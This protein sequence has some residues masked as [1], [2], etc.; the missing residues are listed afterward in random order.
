MRFHIPSTELAGDDP[1]EGFQQSVMAK[2]SVITATGDALA[3]FR[4]VQCLTPRYALN[5]H[6][7]LHCLNYKRIFRFSFSYT[8]V[9]YGGI[10]ESTIQA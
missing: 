3:I 2:A 7:L 5:S 9:D 4:E 10:C 8:H 6:F 1:V